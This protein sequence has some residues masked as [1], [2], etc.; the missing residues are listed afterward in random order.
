M[1]STDTENKAHTNWFLLILTLV[2]LITKTGIV[3]FSFINLVF[4]AQLVFVVVHSFYRYGGKKTLLFFI[5]TFVISWTLETMSIMWGFPFGHYYYIFG[6]KLGLVPWD[7]MFE[8]YMT[9]YFAWTMGSTFLGNFSRNV[10]KKQLFSIPLIGAFIMVMWDLCMDPIITN[11]NHAWVWAEG[12]P[13]FN[14]PI[15]NF[16]GW[17]L[18]TYLIYQ[19]YALY[20]YKYGET[21]PVVQKKSFWIYPTIGYLGVALVYMINPLFIASNL[22]IYWP[23]SLIATFTMFFAAILN[24][25][26]VRQAEIK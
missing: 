18:T 1:L 7:I 8:W 24:L 11:I 13:Y 17:F 4:Y 26:V 6:L 3:K 16:F 15:S 25:I 23:I 10:E 9:G 20:L 5:I 21:K 19:I 22:E 14:V 12:G 2:F